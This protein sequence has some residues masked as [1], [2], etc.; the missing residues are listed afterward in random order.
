MEVSQQLGRKPERFPGSCSEICGVAPLITPWCS[1]GE[2]P[3][4]A[5]LNLSG[6]SGSRVRW[7]VEDEDLFGEWGGST[8]IFSVCL[9]FFRALPL[10]ASA[11]SEQ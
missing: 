5:N 1:E 8:L 11:L 6:S 10:E 3:T 7:H 9:R 4:S 2:A